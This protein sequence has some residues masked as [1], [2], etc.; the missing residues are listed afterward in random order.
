M[1]GAAG[2][3][4]AKE[5]A[6]LETDGTEDAELCALIAVE[7]VVPGMTA[8]EAKLERED[9]MEDADAVTLLIGEG[10]EEVKPLMPQLQSEPNESFLRARSRNTTISARFSLSLGFASRAVPLP[11]RMHRSAAV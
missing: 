6:A 3:T 1:L 2:C 9:H 11:C 8:D 10:V 7:E 4:E 5:D